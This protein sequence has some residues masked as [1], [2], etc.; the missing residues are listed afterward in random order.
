MHFIVNSGYFLKNLQTVSGASGTNA[1]IPV[2]EDFLFELKGNN[3]RI[4]ASDL[5]IMMRIDIEVSQAGDDGRI[6]IP[7]K[8]LIDILKNLPSQPIHF[9]VSHEENR[10][11]IRCDS[12]KYEIMIHNADDF[13]KEPEQADVSS[14]NIAA[15]SLIE[16]INQT[17]FATSNDTLR[18]AMTGVYFQLEHNDQGAVLNLVA[19]DAHRLICTSLKGLSHQLNEGFIVPKKGLLQIRNATPAE[20]VQIE[21]AFNQNYVFVTYNTL[22]MSCR[23]IDAR[24]PDYKAVIPKDNPYELLVNRTD[25]ISVLRRLS[26]IV[27]KGN[28]QVAFDIVGNALT[29]N[30]QDIDFNAKGEE[31]MTCQY[32]GEDMKIAFNIRFM[33][34]S[35]SNLEG[36]EVILELSTPSRAGILKPTEKQ[37][38]KEVIM[39]MMPLMVGV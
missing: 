3:L 32:N 8:T 9:V 20:D 23:L 15:I 38:N 7:S 31:K 1:V 24:F 19:T 18:P 2:L 27:S 13:P 12:G 25:L 17:H 33:I 36:A 34:E 22:H 21:I 5:E 30:A 10:V 26:A 16:A 37:E 4:S 6:C 11:F 28:N 39:L 29:L 35:L 14:F